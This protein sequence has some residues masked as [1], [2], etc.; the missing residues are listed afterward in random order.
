MIK[1]IS[2][3]CGFFHFDFCSNCGYTS[4]LLQCGEYHVLIKK[5]NGYRDENLFNLLSKLHVLFTSFSLACRGRC[6]P[7]ITPVKKKYKNKSDKQ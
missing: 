7:F 2:Q 6:F 1:I 5:K 4:R 3:S